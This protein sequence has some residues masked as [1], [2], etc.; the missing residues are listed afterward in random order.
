MFC[1][2]KIEHKQNIAEK[3]ENSNGQTVEHHIK[4]IENSD[5]EKNDEN[6]NTQNIESTQPNQSDQCIAATLDT[7]N[8]KENGE[9]PNI[10]KSPRADIS[11]TKS[12]QRSAKKRLQ[13]VKSRAKWNKRKTR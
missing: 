1:L 9:N 12:A 13:N 8:L 11:P 7:D 10:T 2:L 3:S 5:A 6:Q 4:E